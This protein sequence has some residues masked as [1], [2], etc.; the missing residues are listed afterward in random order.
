[1]FRCTAE[2]FLCCAKSDRGEHDMIIRRRTPLCDSTNTVDGRPC[3]NTARGCPIAA[4]KESN[5]SGPV[6]NRALTRT[7]PRSTTGG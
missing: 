7:G 4:H 6:P 2:S 5:P 1:M 3:R